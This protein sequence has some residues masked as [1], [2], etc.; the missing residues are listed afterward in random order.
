MSLAHAILGMLTQQP[1]TGYDLKTTC[2]DQSI[3]HF[4]QADQAQ[5]YRTLDK[6]A[7]QGFVTSHLEVQEDRPNRKVYSITDSGHAELL[8]WM[9]TEQALPTY[10]EPFLIQ[11]F[12]GQL[13]DNAQI[14]SIMQQQLEAHQARLEHYRAITLPELDAPYITRDL[15]F[16]RMTLEMGIRIEHAYMDWLKDC[17]ARV[18]SLG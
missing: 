12:F 14:I 16:Q 6:L 7:E 15:L 13:L 1:M 4:W 10:R 8:R 5:I 3:A 9:Q 11:L 17:I 18:Q 2:F